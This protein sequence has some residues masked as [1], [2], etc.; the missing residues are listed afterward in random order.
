MTDEELDEMIEDCPTLYHMAEVGSWPSIRTHGL[1]STSA[2]LD[3]VELSG[4]ARFEVES[5]RRPES[6]EIAHPVH[7]RIVIRTISQ[8]T[9]VACSAASA[10]I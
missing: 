2:V 7:G 5:A 8:W 6:V 3:L 10:T 4:S 9:I 1:L